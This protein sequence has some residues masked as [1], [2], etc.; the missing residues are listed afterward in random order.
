MGPQD[1]TIRIVL[2]NSWYN[3]AICPGA[4]A[5]KGALAST[6]SWPPVTISSLSTGRP[7]L[8]PDLMEQAREAPLLGAS[9]DSVRSRGRLGRT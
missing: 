9:Q 4:G 8:S 2:D 5:T 3:T 6:W 7:R 1:R